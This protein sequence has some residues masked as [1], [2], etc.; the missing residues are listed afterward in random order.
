MASLSD[1]EILDAVARQ[2]Q[3]DQDYRRQLEVAVQSK[4]DSWIKRLIRFVVGDLVEIG[5]AVMAAVT[6]WFMPRQ[7]PW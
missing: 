5:Q 3:T 2:M 1:E 6:G 7:P 4:H